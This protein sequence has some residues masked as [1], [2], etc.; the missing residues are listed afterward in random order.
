M[1]HVSQKNKELSLSINETTQ[2]KASPFKMTVSFIVMLLMASS[3]YLML[4]Q[5][6]PTIKTNLKI[7]LPFIVLWLLIITFID[8]KIKKSRRI[9]LISFSLFFLFFFL[10]SFYWTKDAGVQIFNEILASIGRFKGVYYFGLDGGNS[11]HFPLFLIVLSQALVLVVLLVEH[12][13]YPG[14]LVIWF[15]YLVIGGGLLKTINAYSLA[16][17]L[18]ATV[19]LIIFKQDI[20]A[21]TSIK[22]NSRLIGIITLLIMLILIPIYLLK[23]NNMKVSSEKVNQIQNELKEKKEVHEYGKEEFLPMGILD[24]YSEQRTDKPVLEVKMNSKEPLYLRSFTG[25]EIENNNWKSLTK[26]SLYEDYPLNYWL[27]QANFSSFS[28]LSDSYLATSKEKVKTNKVTIEPVSGST[29]QLFLPY[30]IVKDSS[31][32]SSITNDAFITGNKSKENRAYSFDVTT[33]VLIKYPELVKDFSNM[34]KNDSSNDY[35]LNEANYNEF[36]YKNYLTTPENLSAKLTSISGVNPNLKEHIYYE[37]A[38][39]IVTDYIGQ[40]YKKSSKKNKTPNDFVNLALSGKYTIQYDT[41]AAT[42]ATLLYRHMGI[43]ARYVEGYIITPESILKAEGNSLSIT[44]KE[45]HAWSEIYQDGIGW[46][47]K[48][49]MADYLNM[50]PQPEFE[51]LSFSGNKESNSNATGD[52]MAKSRQELNENNRDN[53]KQI[54]EKDKKELKDILIIIFGSLLLLILVILLIII[55]LKLVK[56]YSKRKK[57]KQAMQDVDRLIASK[58]KLAEFYRLLEMDELS[59]SGGSLYDYL[60]LIQS[61]YH[62]KKLTHLYEKVIKDVQ[63]AAYS[64]DSH[65]SDNRMKRIDKLLELTEHHIY[66]DKSIS[67]KIKMKKKLFY[68]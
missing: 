68:S 65:I 59:L 18:L 43:P 45:A 63:K 58:A 41:E 57:D 1:S 42:L 15:T 54:K 28:Q 21:S 33:D 30:G 61:K 12:F 60:P 7:C 44:G 23:I 39:K 6:S 9:I 29:K 35:L 13:F 40:V 3:F 66:L 19:I 49:S 50:M 20:V 2:I 52:G 55:L 4:S 34:K 47:P 8:L 56:A 48:E 53:L 31:W 38:D 46:V 16:C 17:L 5:F 64:N 62:N 27:N 14:I 24:K 25:K 26:N 67:Q 22:V 36:V 32:E 10:L 37:K 51:G 11:F